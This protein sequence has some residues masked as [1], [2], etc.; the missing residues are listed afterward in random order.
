MDADLVVFDP[1]TISDMGTYEKPNQPAVG[2]Q[3]LLVNGQLV[4]NEGQLILDAAAGRPI[5]R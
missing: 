5:R 1:N 3:I 4:V 2:V